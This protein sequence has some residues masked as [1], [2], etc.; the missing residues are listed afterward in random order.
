[1]TNHNELD[2]LG[3]LVRRTQDVLGEIWELHQSK[4]GKEK[5]KVCKSLWPCRTIDAIYD[6]YT[7]LCP[8]LGR[9]TGH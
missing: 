8:P 9:I 7:Q 5:C 3:D 2:D 1:M 4:T 6:L